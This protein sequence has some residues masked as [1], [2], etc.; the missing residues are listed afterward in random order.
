[1]LIMRMSYNDLSKNG[2]EA[3]LHVYGLGTF[4]VFSGRQ[5]YTNDPNCTYIENSAI[6][7]GRYWVVDR[8]RGSLANQIRS[9][10]LD[11][12]TGND[13]S[14]WLA[15]FS[16]QTM[17]DSMFV[18]K[19]ARGS[20]RLHPLRPDG[21][22]YSEGCITFVSR[23]DFYKVCRFILGMK[24]IRVPGS[25]STMMTYGFVDVQGESK[26]EKCIVR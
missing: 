25:R 3:K 1:M 14:D 18:N 15:L 10:V 8:P 26:F 16:A 21:R 22:G 20:F 4:P 19:I 2:G 24:L 9:W 17:S 7:V 23:L 5:P 6:P 13:H 12:Y 11:Q